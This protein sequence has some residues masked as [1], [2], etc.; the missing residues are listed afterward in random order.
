[1]FSD[2]MK[3]TIC[4]ILAGIM[5]LSVGAVALTVILG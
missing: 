3:K 2:K 5:A 4:L 1:M